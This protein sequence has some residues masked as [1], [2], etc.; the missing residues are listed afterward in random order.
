MDSFEEK[1]EQLMR[2]FAEQREALKA[3]IDEL[4]KVKN[5]I[6]RLF[7]ESLDNRYVR[8]F[9]EKVKAATGIFTAI[10]EIRKEVIKSLK[11]ETE[12]RRKFAQEAGEMDSDIRRLAKSLEAAS[13]V[14][15]ARSYL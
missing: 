5:K 7:P 4:E 12:M 10:L 13:Q 3:M 15:G 8:F 6:E 14:E 11:D 9:E 2:E 1:F